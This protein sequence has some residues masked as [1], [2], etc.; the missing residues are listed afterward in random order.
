M[1]QWSLENW[2]IGALEFGKYGVEE[3]T[4]SFLY[5]CSWSKELSKWLHLATTVE[6]L[7][8]ENST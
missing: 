2:S 8:H 1:E 4:R 3:D 7:L 5:C 6:L